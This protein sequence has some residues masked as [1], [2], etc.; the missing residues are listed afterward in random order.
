MTLTLSQAGSSL[1]GPV[2]VT[3]VQVG[4]S[5]ISGINSSLSG[6][7]AGTTITMTTT[8]LS[9]LTINLTAM[10]NGNQMSGNYTYSGCA[11]QCVQVSTGSFTL[12]KQS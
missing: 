10:V 7:I 2:S 3:C 4:G 1:L 6:S 8:P 12:V 11:A 9:A 5:F